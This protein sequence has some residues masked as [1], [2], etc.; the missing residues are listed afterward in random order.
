MAPRA[1]RQK[2]GELLLDFFPLFLVVSSGVAWLVAEWWWGAAR[3]LVG[4]NKKMK[5]IERSTLLV[6]LNKGLWS[7]RPHLKTRSVVIDG[8]RLNPVVPKRCCFRFQGGSRGLSPQLS[9]VVKKTGVSVKRWS[10]GV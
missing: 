5:K 6:P 8:C 9:L 3:S 10:G 7:G 2:K 1:G 4:I